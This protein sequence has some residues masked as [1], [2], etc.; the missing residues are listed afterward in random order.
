MLQEEETAVIVVAGCWEC[1]DRGIWDF[2]IAKDCY[3]RTISMRMDMSYADLV[4]SITKE[5]ELS[6][7]SFQPK[8]S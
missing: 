3:A 2:K 1:C 5:F 4:S 8:I 7:M 6:G